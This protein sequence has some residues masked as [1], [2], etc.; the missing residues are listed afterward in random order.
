MDRLV[1]P[2]NG[3]LSGSVSYALPPPPPPAN[4]TLRSSVGAVFTEFLLISSTELLSIPRQEDNGNWNVLDLTMPIFDLLCCPPPPPAS[5]GKNRDLRDCA[6]NHSHNHSKY[7][8]GD[9]GS[10][11]TTTAAAVYTSF[12]SIS[13]PL[14]IA[15]LKPRQYD[16]NRLTSM[17][18][19]RRENGSHKKRR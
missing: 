2:P 1:Q 12:W 10:T 15:S 8:T 11:D 16:C 13:H 4:D 3:T 19:R 9:A 6:A 14:A 5:S 18:N 17:L 7:C